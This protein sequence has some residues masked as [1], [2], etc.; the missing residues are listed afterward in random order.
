MP[1]ASSTSNVS[2]QASR[3]WTTSVRPVSFA[4]AIWAA[5][6]SRCAVTGRVVVVVVEAALADRHGVGADEVDDR[7]DAVAGLVRM[8]PDR[9]MDAVV[10]GGDVACGDRR[11]PVAAN[12]DHRRH[13]RGACFGDHRVGRTEPLVVEVA[14]RVDPAV[15]TCS[16][17]DD[18]V[19]TSLTP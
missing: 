18:G 2:S 6:A 3:V 17:C 14:V 12:D 15:Y 7:L 19:G 16:V 4:R 13:A 8:Q 9:G 10:V 5:N 11:R 1:S